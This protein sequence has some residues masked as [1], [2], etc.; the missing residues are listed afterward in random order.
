MNQE[1]FNPVVDLVE[2]LDMHPAVQRVYDMS[3]DAVGILRMKM[4]AQD[5]KPTPVTVNVPVYRRL[6]GGIGTPLLDMPQLIAGVLMQFP[7][8]AETVDVPKRREPLF[9]GVEAAFSGGDG[10]FSWQRLV[11]MVMSLGPGSLN[12]TVTYKLEDIESVDGRLADIDKLNLR[13]ACKTGSLSI[14]VI[15]GSIMKDPRVGK[16]IEAVMDSTSRQKKQEVPADVDDIDGFVEY[17]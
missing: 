17:P 4:V 9:N 14:S 7:A 16:L 3:E 10:G 1:V 6:L 8:F 15:D 11:P 5:S 13:R 12:V 2:V